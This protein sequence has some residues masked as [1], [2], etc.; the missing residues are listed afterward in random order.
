MMQG[1]GGNGCTFPIHIFR[2]TPDP[3]GLPGHL[4]CWSRYRIA[5]M[6]TDGATMR[7]GWMEMSA[8]V[9]IKLSDGTIIAGNNQMVP[10][11][12]LWG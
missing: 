11:F 5:V 9:P 2:K 12:G 6:V 1:I 3:L 10:G 4:V 7:H 8:A